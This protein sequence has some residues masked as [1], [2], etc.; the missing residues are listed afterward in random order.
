VDETCTSWR[1]C[2]K[3]QPLI[4]KLLL[5]IRTTQPVSEGSDVESALPDSQRSALKTFPNSYRNSQVTQSSSMS[6]IL[7]PNVQCRSAS[8]STSASEKM[9]HRWMTVRRSFHCF[10]MGLLGKRGSL[11]CYAIGYRHI[12]IVQLSVESAPCFGAFHRLRASDARCDSRIRAAIESV[13]GTTLRYRPL[14][15]LIESS[16][17]NGYDLTGWQKHLRPRFADLARQLMS[18]AVSR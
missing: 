5:H 1:G 2:I 18:S 11:P 17:R 12:A 7:A 6:H 10:K 8:G 15:R 16:K 4:W 13:S 3:P 14:A 9:A